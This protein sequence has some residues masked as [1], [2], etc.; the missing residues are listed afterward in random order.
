MYANVE[1]NYANYDVIIPFILRA[2]KRKKI[3]EKLKIIE[4]NI[5]DGVIK[6]IAESIQYEIVSLSTSTDRED[7]E[8]REAILSMGR[9]LERKIDETMEA[10]ECLMDMGHGN[11]QMIIRYDGLKEIR[12]EI[13]PNLL[14]KA[15]VVQITSKE[16]I[17]KLGDVASEL[18]K[19]IYMVERGIPP[20]P[21]EG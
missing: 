20:A 11:E 17:N 12:R 8:P 13:L 5:F 9:Y 18:R 15:S 19:Y 3:I 4:K 21:K 1:M 16:Q 6:N 7:K 10:M 14:G 2:R